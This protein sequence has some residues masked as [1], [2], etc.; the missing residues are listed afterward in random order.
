[1]YHVE[2][3]RRAVEMLAEFWA[4]ADSATRSAITRAANTIE[5]Q[6]QESPLS[7]GESRG[8]NRRVLFVGP[9]LII[10]QVSERLREVQVLYCRGLQRWED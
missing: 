1:M 7:Y 3:R 8:E 4:V 2:W 10:Y 6:L 9:L 5:R